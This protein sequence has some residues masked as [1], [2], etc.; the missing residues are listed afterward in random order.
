MEQY[1]DFTEVINRLESSLLEVRLVWTDQTAKTYDA[2][3]ENMQHFALH[4]WNNYNNA[5]AG[6]NMV[7]SNYNEDDFEQVFNNLNTKIEAV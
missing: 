4:I 7:R 5:V 3:N 2:I 6:K 1:G